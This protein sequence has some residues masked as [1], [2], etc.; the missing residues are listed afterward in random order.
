MFDFI[1]QYFKLRCNCEISANYTGPAV[2]KEICI[3]KYT[4]F[5][6]SFIFFCFN[7]SWSSQRRQVMYANFQRGSRRTFVAF[8]NANVSIYAS[9]YASD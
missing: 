8:A 2:C 4:V 3:C 1:L 9:D 6:V 7:A 5:E